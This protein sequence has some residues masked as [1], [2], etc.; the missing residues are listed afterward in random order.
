MMSYP[1]ASEE[2]KDNEDFK[3]MP[4]RTEPID[5]N[6]LRDIRDTLLQND[7]DVA[8]K[9]NKA[10]LD[11]QIK[12]LYKH[13]TVLPF[14]PIY[15]NEEKKGETRV[16][17]NPANHRTGLGQLF[18][19]KTLD[20]AENAQHTIKD[21][22]NYNYPVSSTDRDLESGLYD[23][24]KRDAKYD[25]EAGLGGKA[26]RKANKHRKSHKSKKFRKSRKVRKSKKSRKTRK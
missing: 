20:E 12:M 22:V 18:R 26:T 10:D 16:D 5:A 2:S 4:R 19:Y 1:E 6:M 21:G 14:A 11:A 3:Q 15:Y 23:V 9:Y 17:S 25:I 24:S 7:R 8:K 13:D